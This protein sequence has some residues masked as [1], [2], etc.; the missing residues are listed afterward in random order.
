M[1]RLFLKA[2][3]ALSVCLSLANPLPLAAQGFAMPRLQATKP[4]AMEK[5]FLTQ[6]CEEDPSQP[7]CAPPAEDGGQPPA[8]APEQGTEPAAAPDAGSAVDTESGA[9]P[10]AVAPDAPAEQAPE[11][12]VES[13]PPEAVEPAEPAPAQAAPAPV[14]E[15]P[16]QAAP[17]EAASSPDAAPAEPAPEA[18]QEAPA[19]IVPE[20]VQDAPAEISPEAAPAE[21]APE[22]AP[23][24]LAPD[25]A[26]TAD[27]PSD[28]TPTVGEEP[29]STPQATEPAPV[30][31]APEAPAAEVAPDAASEP[32]APAPTTPEVV[33]EASGE[34]PLATP[35]ENA[36]QAPASGAE[37]ATPPA[38][39]AAPTEGASDD[40]PAAPA[41][42]PVE[43]AGSAEVAPVA[44]PVVAPTPEQEQVLET[45]MADPETAAA[46]DTLSQ[47]LAP[48]QGDDAGAGAAL[49]AA[50]AAAAGAEATPP[51]ETTTQT[52]GAAETRS[53][54]QDFATPLATTAPTTVEEDDDD[55]GLSDLEKAGLLA[56][57]AV[58][59]GM[60]I[61]NNRVVAKS[62]DRVVVDRGN[63]D[64]AI[65]KDDDAILRTP[66][67]VETTQ[68]YNDGSTLTR[69]ARRD[70]SEIITVRDATG[71]VVRR[72]LLR[73]D[74]T[75]VPIIDDTRN[76]EPVVI[77]EL[78]RPRVRSLN[79]VEDQDP[80]MWR[81]LLDEAEQ[82]DPG[83]TFS[84]AQIRNI[85]EVRELAPELTAGTITFET[86]SAAIRPD[87]ARKLALIA[88]FMR[89]RIEMNPRELFLV[90]GHTDAVGSAAYNLALSDRRAESIARALSEIFGVPAENMVVQ[91]YGERYLRVQTQVSEPANRRVAVRQVTWLMD[92]T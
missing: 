75:S 88:E 74:G 9:A 37:Q 79:L 12:A 19:E 73:A 35:T 36:P 51:A 71:R 84:L 3:T 18:V 10:E 30:E 14:Q 54:A 42:Q 72:E 6:T 25:P 57:G 41:G 86:G 59:V 90:E 55:N 46:V 67:V 16:A 91:G 61:N 53:S 80:A 24:E 32:E 1:T 58:A 8:P 45:M 82:A 27:A 26:P 65:W 87:E 5:P 48:E 64:L 56:L 63:G 21:T 28:A 62:G 47:A 85:R 2:T 17:A 15:E 31:A 68:R 52:L 40:S 49:A 11:A 39:G 66:G 7:N 70:G 13:A 20:A 22:A 92:E 76:Y 83:R 50:A 60:L 81:A 44:D 23:A 43:Q 34:Q 33:P 78:P 29:A 69:L 89:D 4:G 38:D 77:S